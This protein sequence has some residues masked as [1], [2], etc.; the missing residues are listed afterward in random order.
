MTKQL[1]LYML[2]LLGA[3]CFV[4]CSSDDD[5]PG[6]NL[7][8]T[9][10]VEITKALDGTSW[11]VTYDISSKNHPEE[12]HGKWT[13]RWTFSADGTITA[14]GSEDGESYT[15]RYTYQFTSAADG[16]V[17]IL[18]KYNRY[19]VEELTTKSFRLAS[20]DQFDIEIITGR[21]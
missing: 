21:R 12:P 16:L 17:F 9:E 18:D 20:Y 11:T 14:V 5:E 8:A 4:G 2:A 13:E 1:F 7:I 15:D 19:I 3:V 10:A 6:Q